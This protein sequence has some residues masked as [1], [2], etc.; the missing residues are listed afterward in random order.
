M[1]R[2]RSSLSCDLF[3]VIGTSSV[4]HPAASLFL[5]AKEQGAYTVELNLETTPI[6]SQVDLSLEGRADV[7]LEEVEKMLSL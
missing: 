4:V 1:T 6:S 5:E 2:C 7:I 3:I